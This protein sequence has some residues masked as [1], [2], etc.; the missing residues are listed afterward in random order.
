MQPQLTE[1]NSTLAPIRSG[2]SAESATPGRRRIVLDSHRRSPETTLPM[3]GQPTSAANTL[4]ALRARVLRAGIALLAIGMPIGG[5]LMAFQAAQSGYLNARILAFSGSMLCFPLLWLLTP[6]LRFRTAAAIFIAL[7]L[8]S[9]TL[10]ASRGVL[11]VGYA[12]VDLLVI[13]SSTLFF[14]RTGAVVGMGGVMG[15]HLLGWGIVSAG[16]GPPPPLSLIDPRLPDVWIRHVV[17]LGLL[18]LVMA[19]TELFVIE[20]L[21]REVEVHRAQRVALDRV[22]HE[23]EHERQERE[24]AH[25]ALDQARRLEALA[26]LSGGI[27]HDFNNALT[28]IIGTADVAKLSLSSPAEVAGYL[29]EIVDAARRAGQ[30]TRQLLTLGQ[31]QIGGR[32]PV[33]MPDFLRRLEGAL[34]RVLPDDI[35]LVVDAPREPI[36]AFT[37]VAGLERAVYNLVLNARD[38]IQSG[39]GTITIACQRETIDCRDPLHDGS[40]AVLRVTDTGHGMDAQTLERIFDPFFTTKGERGG[41]GLGLATVYAFA[42]ETDGHVD[43]TSAVGAGTTFTLW[44]PEHVG[45]RR[46]PAPAE[47]LLPGPSRAPHRTRILVV[48]DRAD[49]RANMVRTLTTY[50]FDVEEAVDGDAAMARLEQGCD[51]AAMCIDGVMPGLSTAEVLARAALIAP[52]MGVLL[53]SGYLREEL[54]RRGVEAGRYAFLAKPF[55]PD[56][57]LAGVD[58]VLRS[59]AAAR[60]S[61]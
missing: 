29:D 7:L 56:Q 19:L 41:T 33:D 14:G 9:A 12:A 42:K 5:A 30:L 45:D 53:C 31:G 59:S 43:V 49:V 27:A 22:E 60:V 24:R 50:G 37:N 32:E 28:V 57:L 11:T 2:A 16:L 6:R 48:E 17:I 55:T 8:G 51:F 20:Q 36:T 34:R 44:L 18:G 58:G 47:R 3:T 40:Y 38:A 39:R 1:A 52:G 21:A 35:A 23:R 25:L 46:P 61:R 10:L 4:D 15:A 13:L 26:R 54:L